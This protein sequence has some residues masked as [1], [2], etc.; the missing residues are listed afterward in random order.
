MLCIF[1]NYEHFLWPLLQRSIDFSENVLETLF[2]KR[3]L[4][5]INRSSPDALVFLD[6]FCRHHMNRDMLCIG[7]GLEGIQYLPPV[8]YR[9]ND[10]Q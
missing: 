5:K 10:V 1:L 9:E 8:H 2:L 3:F 4:D 6:L 7:T